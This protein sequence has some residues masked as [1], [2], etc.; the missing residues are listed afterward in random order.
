MNYTTSFN[1]LKLTHAILIAL[2]AKVFSIC[3]FQVP[4]SFF[5]PVLVMILLLLPKP[6]AISLVYIFALI[7]DLCFSPSRFGLL[8]SSYFI[9]SLVIYYFNNLLF[10][11]KWIT[12][13]ILTAIFSL[14]SNLT[15]VTLLSAING[16]IPF[17][18]RLLFFELILFP[19]SDA[20]YAFFFFTAPTLLLPK[21]YLKSFSLNHQTNQ[22]SDLS[23]ASNIGRKIPLSS[24]SV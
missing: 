16:V 6:K 15:H 10:Y 21:Q 22:R 19:I 24:D 12:L 2:W 14:L 9:T 4:I 3:F 8:T 13:P 7:T 23:H 11:D 20:F 17:S 5:H 1:G 18:T